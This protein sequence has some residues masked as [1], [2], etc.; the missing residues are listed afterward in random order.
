MGMYLY[1]GLAGMLLLMYSLSCKNNEDNMWKIYMSIKGMLY[2]YTEKCEE[3]LEYLQSRN[4]GAYDGEA[5]ILYVYLLL[6]KRSGKKDYLVYAKKHAKILEKLIGDDRRFDLLV[7]NA[8]AAQVLL[9]LYDL[10][11]EK[12]YLDL[13][14]YAIEILES[15][16]EKQKRGVGWLVEA[17]LP[18]MEGMAHGSSGI[19]IPVIALWKK[20]RKKNIYI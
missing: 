9:L 20:T 15:K 3:S 5:S 7:G 12:R 16:A 11:L 19:I 13:A 18:P 17:N 8:G 14:E 6:Y 1:D 4:T 2:R 10:V